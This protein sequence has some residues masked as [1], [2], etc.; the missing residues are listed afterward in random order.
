MLLWYTVSARYRHEAP[1]MPAL[2]QWLNTVLQSAYRRMS[3]TQLVQ[4]QQFRQ[5]T[6]G[7]HE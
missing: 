3:A 4:W 1:Q 2:I 6:Q 5:Q 7:L